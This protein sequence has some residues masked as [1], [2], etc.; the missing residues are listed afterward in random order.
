MKKII[1]AALL[2]L[3]IVLGVAIPQAAWGCIVETPVAADG[4]GKPCG[5][6]SQGSTWTPVGPLM[7]P[8]DFGHL[9]KRV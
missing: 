7:A 5:G 9:V 3:G 2:T 8:S 4:R 1:I 6:V